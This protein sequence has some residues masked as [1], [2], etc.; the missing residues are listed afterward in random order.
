MDIEINIR[1]GS[2][3]R[4]E[5]GTVKWDGYR[6]ASHLVTYSVDEKG[7]MREALFQVERMLRESLG[8]AG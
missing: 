7:A 8:A 5:T 4:L 2:R 6:D 1:T 3:R